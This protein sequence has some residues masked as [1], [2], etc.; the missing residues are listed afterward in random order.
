MDLQLE[1]K[2]ALVTGGC[3]GLGR[4]T[5][6]KFLSLGVKV[7]VFDLNID[8]AQACD[9][10]SLYKVNVTDEPQV[11]AALSQVIETYGE[12][13]ICVNC[14]GI[15]PARKVLDREAT[16]IPLQGFK[17]VIDINL[18]GTFSVCA[19]VAEKMAHNAPQEDGER[20][21]MINTASIAAFEGQKGQCAYAASKGGIVSLTLP[22]ARDLKPFGIRVATIA[23]G[24]MGTD[25]V[26]A[27]PESV[28]ES[29]VSAI[30][31]PKRLGYPQEYANLAA[32]I[33]ENT[34]ING[35]VIRLDGA[36]R[37]Q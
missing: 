21:V 5:V 18:V 20:G 33:V 16:R 4:A 24:V 37:M 17:Q 8:E 27:M 35:E 1:N 22:M 25:M 29:L 36:L 14:A 23:P 2:V 10:L 31:F 3:S 34:Y 30:P 12:I 7:A 6:E 13:H 9:G 11:Q 32:H 19:Q 28:Q 15:A 26:K